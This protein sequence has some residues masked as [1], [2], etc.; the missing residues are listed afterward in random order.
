MSPRRTNSKDPE[1][2]TG[3]PAPGEPAFLVVGK[4]RRPHGVAGEILLEVLTDF[5]Q[6]VGPGRQ[7]F[8]GET[9]RPLLILSRRATEKG[10]LLTLEGYADMDQ[11]AAL[12]NQLLYVSTDSLPP[13]PEGEYYHHQLLGLRVEDKT[14][15]ALGHISDILETGATN[16]YVVKS[17]EGKELLI[18][19]VE[20]FVQEI[21]LEKGVMRVNPP[22]WL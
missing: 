21:D 2:K 12:T 15:Q 19:A 10:L 13:L 9:H 17:E 11:V 20:P 14:G 5:P 22:E 3:S 4:F 6:R 16:V 8:V 1:T 7:F 18:P